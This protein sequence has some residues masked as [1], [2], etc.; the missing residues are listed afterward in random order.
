MTFV[1]T[2]ESILM[3]T[4]LAIVTAIAIIGGTCWLSL[5]LYSWIKSWF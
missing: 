2:A 5:K 3:A 1:W 4:I